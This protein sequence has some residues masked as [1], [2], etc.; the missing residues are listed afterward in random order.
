RTELVAVTSGPEAEAG[1]VRISARPAPMLGDDA[2][3]LSFEPCSTT[4]ILARPE[5][6]ENASANELIEQLERELQATREDLRS[7][8]EELEA[9]S[10]ELRSSSEHS[11]LMNEELQSANEELE[12]TTEELRSLNEELTTVNAQLRE[13]V[14]QAEQA[15]DDLSNFFSSTKVATIFLDERLCI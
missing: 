9:A 11:T 5:R 10:E 12:A 4:V 6:H 13:K 3:I 14:E 2:V 7:T 15:H 8:A 1:C